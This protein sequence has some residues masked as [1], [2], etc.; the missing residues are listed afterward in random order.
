MELDGLQT[1]VFALPAQPTILESPSPSA[2]AQGNDFGSYFFDPQSPAA[3]RAAE[4][5]VAPASR[6]RMLHADLSSSPPGSS[7][8]NRPPQRP[9]LA[10]RT[11]DRAHS[12][13]NVTTQG[14]CQGAIGAVSSR[15]S[16]GKRANPY[17]RRPSLAQD[18]GRAL[19]SAYPILGGKQRESERLRTTA[20]AP[21][22]CQSVCDA[23]ATLGLGKGPSPFTSGMRAPNAFANQ[24]QLRGSSLPEASPDSKPHHGLDLYPESGSPM[25]AKI[26]SRPGMLRRPSKDDSS[27]LGYGTG[28]KRESAHKADGSDDT[29]MGGKSPM[30]AA[31]GSPFGAES[32]PGFGASEK[33]GKVLPCFTVKDDGLMRITPDTLFELL[34]GAYDDR[35]E[36]YHII[37]CRFDYEYEGG[38]IPGAINLSTRERVKN[39]FL[40]PGQ[41][42]HANG[43]QLPCRSQSGKADKHGKMSKPVLI[44]H[45]EFSCQRA[46]KMALTLRQA[47]R[48]LAHDYPNCHFPEVYI[49]QG[50]YC[51]FFKTYPSACEPKEYI[52]MDD[53]RFQDR[54]SS[55]L[56]GFRKQ[57][58][59]HRSFT[60]GDTRGSLT[61]SSMLG[62]ASVVAPSFVKS[63]EIAA[64]GNPS[65]IREEDSAAEDSPCIMGAGGQERSLGRSMFGTGA[66]DT[67]I[68]SVGDSSFEGG[69]GDSP[70]AAA[71]SRRPSSL[72]EPPAGRAGQPRGGSWGRHS[73]A[74]AGTT[75]NILTTGSSVVSPLG[76]KALH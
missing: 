25:A 61:S 43:K 21:R 72:L 38:H 55:E 40:K 16:L 60:F 15:T 69:I 10:S 30:G 24:H 26:R 1:S 73:F 51:E 44:F 31:L 62:G 50:G 45:C 76:Q 5:S 48:A 14:T 33:E 20:P 66:E 37:D 41:G 52:R 4:V 19:K 42:L 68:G 57:F 18:T 9:S 7:P 58:A 3:Q 56:N 75:A 74:R 36:S 34:S 29:A 32:M 17:S 71:G 28:R 67:S 8:S 35:L 64:A 54:R 11:F 47:D 49:L 59:R 6:R 23:S 12:V 22:R 39:H 63:S 27:P 53:P 46:P 70:C 65:M 13:A 2:L